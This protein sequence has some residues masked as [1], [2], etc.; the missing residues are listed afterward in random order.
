MKTALVTT[1]INIPTVLALYRKLGPDVEIFVTGDMKTP[2]PEAYQF[3]AELGCIAKVPQEQEGWACS[4][5]IG[6]NTIR[7]RNI[8]VLEALKWGADVIVTIDDDNIPLG[9]YF[10]EIRSAFQLEVETPFGS[11]WSDGLHNGLSITT[12]N[13]WFDPGRLMVPPTKHRGFPHEKLDPGFVVEPA[14]GRRVGVVA[15]LCLGDPDIDA[16]TRIARAAHYFFRIR[17]SARRRHH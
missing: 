1:T 9:Y 11:A 12:A 5:L 10:H 7:R 17:T 14:V 13:G 2:V 3:M 15:G 8:A 4:E 6:W 16:V